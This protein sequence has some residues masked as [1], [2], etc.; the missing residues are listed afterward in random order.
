MLL[1]STT[2]EFRR[3]SKTVANMK[4]A[5]L[6]LILGAVFVA[7]SPIAVGEES[8]ELEKRSLEWN[9][10][11]G[12]VMPRAPVEI[13][14]QPAT[15]DA[16]TVDDM[17]ELKKG[18]KK[19]KTR[20]TLTETKTRTKTKTGTTTVAPNP[21]SSTTSTYFSSSRSDLICALFGESLS[22]IWS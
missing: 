10:K 12:P 13:D 15:Q 8:V 5:I 20:L 18:K 3:F 9:D 6:A 19:P 17:N 2:C 16:G 22:I 14:D 11:L 21:T 1:I 4:S 7:A